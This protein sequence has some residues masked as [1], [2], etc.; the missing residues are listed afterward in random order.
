[1]ENTVSFGDCPK[2]GYL[3]GV[4]VIRII[5]TILGSIWGPPIQGNYPLGFHVQG[6][7]D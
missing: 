1:M 6:L 4:L 5:I 2:E 7:G 3:L